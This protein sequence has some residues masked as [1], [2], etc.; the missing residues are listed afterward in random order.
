MEHVN[1]A[2]SQRIQADARYENQLTQNETAKAHAELNVELAKLN[3]K[4]YVDP[5]SGTF[6]LALEN[7][8]RLIDDT[9]NDI[10]EA[11]AASSPAM[12]VGARLAEEMTTSSGGLESPSS[13]VTMS[14]T[15]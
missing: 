7:I 5:D 11:Q 14:W 1:S 8:E 9:R 4:R 10:L 3:L 12:A 15:R 6:K 13:S 2:R